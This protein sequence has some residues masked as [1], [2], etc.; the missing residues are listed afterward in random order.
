ML[1]TDMFTYDASLL[2]KEFVC[3]ASVDE[4]TAARPGLL[5]GEEAGILTLHDY[6]WSLHTHPFP[7][8]LHSSD[9]H[10]KNHVPLQTFSEFTKI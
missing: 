7:R 2:W 5:T 4:K 10:A 9:T 6:S 3:D 1:S 8:H